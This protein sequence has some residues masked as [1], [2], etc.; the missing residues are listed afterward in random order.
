MNK[1]EFYNRPAHT[2]GF[3]ANVLPAG[4]V[5]FSPVLPPVFSTAV[6][7][8]GRALS[9]MPGQIS[10][11]RPAGQVRDIPGCNP[12]ETTAAC[13]ARL[14]ASTGGT[15]QPGESQYQCLV[16]LQSLPPTANNAALYGAIGSALGTVGTTVQ[17]I[18][19]SGDQRAIAA[20][21]SQTQIRIAE[22]DQQAAEA[23]AAG[24]RALADQLARQSAAATNAASSLRNQ[25]LLPPP[26]NT[27]LYIGLA[28]AGVA[29]LGVGAYMFTRPKRN[30]SYA[31]P[32]RSRRHGRRR[33]RRNRR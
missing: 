29:V 5:A 3:N 15:C 1:V 17:A 9:F 20:L 4:A 19:T 33:A 24:N 31:N 11:L 23:L 8:A 6:R 21:Q 10:G 22:I 25:G 26:N 14:Q 28:I 7:P 32:H 27:P 13:L 12:G 18:L 16:R 30:P 2:F